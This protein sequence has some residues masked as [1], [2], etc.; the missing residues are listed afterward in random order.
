MFNKNKL[1]YGIPQTVVNS[2]SGAIPESD[3]LHYYRVAKSAQTNK[4]MSIR[5]LMIWCYQW[6][7]EV[8]RWH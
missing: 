3:I 8:K 2:L 1:I 6:D 7:R 4:V 5:D